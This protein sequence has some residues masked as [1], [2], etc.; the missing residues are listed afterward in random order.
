MSKEAVETVIGKALL[1]E[2]FREALLADPGQALAG[3]DLTKVEI[4][5]LKRLDGETLDALARSL[6][7]QKRKLRLGK[8]W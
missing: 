7:E 8:V 2:G 4:D 5:G 6:D 3:F 1:D